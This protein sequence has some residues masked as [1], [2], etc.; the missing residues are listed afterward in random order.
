MVDLGIKQAV[1]D[2]LEK[3]WNNWVK[4]PIIDKTQQLEASASQQINTYSDKAKE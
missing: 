2:W 4:Q 3:K 1:K